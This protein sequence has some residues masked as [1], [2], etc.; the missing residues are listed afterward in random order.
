MDEKRSKMSSTQTI[1]LSPSGD[2]NVKKK[3]ENSTDFQIPNIDITPPPNLA[4]HEK[5]KDNKRLNLP[6][7]KRRDGELESVWW[8]H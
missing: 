5:G 6:R 7:R 3:N 8:V 1:L 4:P 2:D